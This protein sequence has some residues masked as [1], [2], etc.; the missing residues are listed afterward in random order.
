MVHTELLNKLEPL[1]DGAR[2]SSTKAPEMMVGIPFSK[3]FLPFTASPLGFI[4]MVR[5]PEQLPDLVGNIPL[6]VIKRHFGSI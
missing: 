4:S 6:I 1:L 5:L 3:T 2:I